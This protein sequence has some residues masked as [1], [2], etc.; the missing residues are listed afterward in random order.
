[1]MIKLLHGKNNVWPAITALARKGHRNKAAVAFVSTGAR[2]LLP[3]TRG[4]TL[5]VD[6]SLERVRGGAT[7]P[8][9]VEEFFKKGVSVFTCHGLHAKVFILG[10][11]VVV[12]SANVSAAANSAL[13][14]AVLITNERVIASAAEK[15]IE[16]LVDG[17]NTRKVTEPM[18][19]QLKKEFRETG[20]H[21]NRSA[22][23]SSQNWSLSMMR[24]IA[25]KHVVTSHRQPYIALSRCEAIHRIYLTGDSEGEAQLRL[26]PGDTQ[27]QAIPFYEGVNVDRLTGLASRDNRWQVEPNFHLGYRAQGFLHTHTTKRLKPYLRFW[28][29]PPD[30]FPIAAVKKRDYSKL[31]RSLRKYGMFYTADFAK[32][33]IR[34]RNMPLVS[35]R[36]GVAI[37]FTWDMKR[38]TANEV[39]ARIS[40]ALGT[41]GESVI[42]SGGKRH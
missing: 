3:L 40:E 24:R 8:F 17:S 34:I 5:V 7:N 37:T 36:P 16:E 11:R 33:Q 1:M 21:G 39:K 6:M 2:K 4:D 12:G 30:D 15:F 13:E 23:K 31:A 29:K 35:I 25:P 14:E 26:Y 22:N 20:W 28:K 42:W 10:N 18:L 41:W 32:L 19:K 27:Q 9:A 38:P